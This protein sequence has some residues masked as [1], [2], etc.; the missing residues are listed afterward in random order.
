M[1]QA[2]CIDDLYHAVRRNSIDQCPIRRY[3]YGVGTA[4]EK[5]NSY[6][7]AAQFSKS[8]GWKPAFS[9]EEGIDRT[10]EDLL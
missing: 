9:L 3:Y 7:N 4:L 2:P 1:L 8:A 10:L 5:R 6:V